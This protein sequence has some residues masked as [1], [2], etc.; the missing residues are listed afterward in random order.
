MNTTKAVDSPVSSVV[1]VI[2]IGILWKNSLFVFVV[3]MAPVKTWPPLR[4]VILNF[5]GR[6]NIFI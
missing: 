1:I 4:P 3:I 2:G 6:A 5:E